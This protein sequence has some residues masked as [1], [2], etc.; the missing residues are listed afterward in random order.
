MVTGTAPAVSAATASGNSVT[1]GLASALTSGQVVTVA[2]VDA[3]SGNDAAA[4]QDAAGND[5]ANFTTGAGEVPA[6][7]NAVGTGCSFADG[8]YLVSAD[9]GLIPTGLGAGAEFRLVF[10]SSTT[11]NATPSDIADYNTF[12][13]D[14]AA[15]GHADIQVYS[16]TAFKVV[17]STADV[18]ARDN[19]ATT[20][21]A[22][23]KGGVDLLARTA[24]R[25]PTTT[26]TSTTGTWD[27]ESNRKDESGSDVGLIDLPFT[28]SYH[29]G[30]EAFNGGNSN[31]LGASIVRVGRPNSSTSGNGPLSSATTFSNSTVSQFYGL[32]PVFRVAAGQV[33]VTNTA[34]AFSS[35][36]VV[37]DGREPGGYVPGD[38][39]WTPTPGMR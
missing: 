26:R 12:I 13:Q 5:A 21:T 34:P 8:C 19:T 10:F 11:R 14:L 37:L 9:W 3:T 4:V 27:D 2:Y 20:Y 16:S 24:T 23:D 6:V 7:S 22:D 25:W 17:G 30:T 1:L 31:A 29:E 38:G 39:R 33:V 28:G 35:A 15:A 18:D 36:A 32:S